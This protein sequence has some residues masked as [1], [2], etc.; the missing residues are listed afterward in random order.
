M[1]INA[2][3][4]VR[5]KSLVLSIFLHCVIFFIIFVA[6]GITKKTSP[7]I[8]I[9]LTISSTA[10]SGVKSL[11]KSAGAAP[12]RV[13]NKPKAVPEKPR[14][15]VHAESEKRQS[16]APAQTP[17]PPVESPGPEN[18]P[19]GRNNGSSALVKSETA[20]TFGGAGPSSQGIQIS[21]EEGRGDGSVKSVEQLKNGYLNEHFKYIRDLIQRNISYPP[22]ARR[23][24]W[25]GRAVVSFVINENGRALNEKILESSGFE[26]LDSN[27]IETIRAVSPF[28]KPPVKAE[29]RVPINYRLE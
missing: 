7:P 23:M 3:M 29:L 25:S 18:V 16:A 11:Q 27:V 4:T 19:E 5:R 17:A 28:P 8:I 21:A 20:G 14:A 15:I 6:S 22:R 10:S 13:A 26:V 12:R 1:R 24:G 9:D 2:E